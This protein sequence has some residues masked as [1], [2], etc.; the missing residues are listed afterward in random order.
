MAKARR[1]ALLAACV[2]AAMLAGPAQAQ[3]PTKAQQDAV[4]AN[5][6][7][8]FL[9]LCRG[10]TPGGTEALGCLKQNAARLAPSCKQAVDVINLP[11]SAAPRSALPEPSTVGAAPAPEA[12][13]VV[14]QLGPLQ[15]R[16]FQMACGADVQIHCVGVPRDPQSRIA[17]LRDNAA[18]LS[19]PC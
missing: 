11:G 15:A 6:R 8:D 12:P 1:D 9:S 5:C 19:P 16:N 17:C 14:A 3:Q 7:S 4:R 10:V 18:S 13:M 2:T